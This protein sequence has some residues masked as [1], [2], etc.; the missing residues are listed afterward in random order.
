M[1]SKQTKEQMYLKAV[2]LSKHVVGIPK[3]V[4]AWQ[5]DVP[6]HRDRPYK[7]VS[8]RDGIPSVAPIGTINPIED[9]GTLGSCTG[10]ASTSMLEIKLGYPYPLSRLMAYYNGRVIDGTVKSDA[11][12]QIRSVIKGLMKQGVCNESTWP[13]KPS[14]FATMPSQA[15]RVEALNLSAVDVTQEKFGYYRVSTLDELLNALA[16]GNTVTFGFTVPASIDALPKSGVL[17][18]PTKT[19]ASMGGHAVLAVGFDR[20]KKFIW[21]RNSWGPDWGLKGYFKMPFAWFTDPRRLVDDMWTV[22]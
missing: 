15:A 2:A 11:G 1:K 8:K 19:E 10:N 16:G 3:R 13:Y 21:V 12:A 17:K 4:Y 20:T 18:L 7:L 22:I 5:P 14:K 9:Q 6:D